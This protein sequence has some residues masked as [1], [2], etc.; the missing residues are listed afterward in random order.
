MAFSFTP[1]QK[2]SWLWLCV[3]LLLLGLLVMLGPVLTPFVSAAIL[4]YA[5]NPLVDWLA[6]RHIGRWMLPR[7]LAVCIVLLLLI[8]LLL[9]LVLVVFPVMQKEF[10]SMR[11]QIP[12]LLRNLDALLSPRLHALGI[13]I[14][15]DGAGLQKI[16]SEQL[17][18]SSEQIWSTALTSAR[19]G[20]VAVLGWLATFILIPVVL[21]YLLLDWHTL[22]A[23]MAN[24][25]PRRWLAKVRS[26]AKETDALLAQYLRGQLAVM[27][28]L[29]LFYSITLTLV[30]LDVALPIGIIT[31]L[32][33][34]IPYLGFG[35]GLVLAM[36][37]G[38]LQFSSLQGIVLVGA[39]YGIGQ[40]LE[41]FVL[42]PRLVGERI[43]L[44]P[45][46][47][48]FALL[49]FGELFGFV[50]VLVALPASAILSVAY[51]HV[52]RA[53]LHSSFYNQ[54]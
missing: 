25:V 32:L 9:G 49:A 52:R 16:L 6:R 28:S 5:L 19:I 17:G 4:A 38:I 30:G 48:I 31:G 24:N 39:V 34:F 33:S 35:L 13:K 43:G 14:R 21:F 27:L 20:G 40:I 22:L 26:L 23:R 54:A 29:A 46:I 11:E 3:A 45:L 42:T 50:G 36:L 2:Q 47:V 15:L 53:Y 41:S 18:A 1:E 12:G 8:A 7:A 44:S 37:A 10:I 51:K